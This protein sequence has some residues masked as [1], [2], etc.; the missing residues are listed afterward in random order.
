MLLGKVWI[1]DGADVTTAQVCLV[2]NS[3]TLAKIC[4]RL[5]TGDAQT[6]FKVSYQNVMI[7]GHKSG[8]NWVYHV[9]FN[10]R[11]S[12]A[13]LKA[14]RDLCKAVAYGV[15]K[16]VDFLGEKYAN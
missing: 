6:S 10:G 4:H 11:V 7:S 8:G 12:A 9:V 1:E 5:L 13:K 2:T 15:E 14:A 16:R 3:E